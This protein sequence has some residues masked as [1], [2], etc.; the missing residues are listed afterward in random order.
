MKIQSK[1]P[2][3]A[4]LLLAVFAAGAVLHAG[5]AQAQGPPSGI[6]AAAT[7]KSWQENGAGGR[8]LLQVVK[9]KLP[10]SL[11]PVTGT[12]TSDTDCDADAQGLSHCH[13]NVKLA[14]GT[15]I[16]VRDQVE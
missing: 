15:E 16:T 11:Q 12:V 4:G 13:N 3:P 8:Y 5:A 10:K 2:P 14:D 1:L 7:M 9:G 6:P